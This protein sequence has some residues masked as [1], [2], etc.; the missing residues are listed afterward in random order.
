[1]SD[2]HDYLSTSENSKFRLSADVLML[3]LKGAGYAAAFCLAL[4]FIV[5]ALHW[6]GL[7]LPEDSKYRPDPTPYSFYMSDQQID[8]V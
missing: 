2:N 8:L 3:M 6:I 7:L 4:W 1:M 5:V